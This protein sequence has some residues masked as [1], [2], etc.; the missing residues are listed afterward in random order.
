MIQASADD[1]ASRRNGHTTLDGAEWRARTVERPTIHVTGDLA[2][3]TRLSWSAIDA[4]N[5]PPFLYLYGG[6][7]V[8]LEREQDGGGL[9]TKPLTFHRMRYVLA[10]VASY[11]EGVK[12]QREVFPPAAVV[13]DVLAAPQPSLPILNGIVE[14][15]VLTKAGT[16]RALAGYHEEAGIAY[17]PPPG[18]VMPPGTAASRARRASRGADA[19]DE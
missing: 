8:R 18:F 13:N 19:P 9:V 11:T 1:L 3:I 6:I 15:P 14:V 12:R 5:H 16:I 17:E 10:R 2:D 4:A 7:P